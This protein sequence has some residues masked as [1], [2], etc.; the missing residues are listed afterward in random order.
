M[1]SFADEMEG[2]ADRPA[3]QIEDRPDDHRVSE[4]EKGCLLDRGAHPVELQ[5]PEILADDRAD[6]AG[7]REHQAKGDRHDASD[8][9]ESG[10]HIV[11][12]IGDEA[13][14]YETAHRRRNIGQYGGNQ[15]C[16]DR[17]NISAKTGHGKAFEAAIVSD[18]RRDRE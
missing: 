13:I 11:R 12:I 6:G 1:P 8:N 4:S 18:D 14:G 10:N 15:Y 16:H 17:W 3:E 2:I 7:K 5:C 9:R